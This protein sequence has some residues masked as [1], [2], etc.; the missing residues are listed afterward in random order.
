MAEKQRLAADRMRLTVEGALG[1]YLDEPADTYDEQCS[2]Q[3]EATKAAAIEHPTARRS[4]PRRRA[5]R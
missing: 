5:R 4:L 2:A 1:D 3:L